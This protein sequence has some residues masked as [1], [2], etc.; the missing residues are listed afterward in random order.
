MMRDY[1]SKTGR[2][3]KGL[4]DKVKYSSVGRGELVSLCTRISPKSYEWL[5]TE[6]EKRCKS[7]GQVIDEVLFSMNCH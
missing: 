1:E 7:M 3:G 5:M 2:R 6:S 4:C